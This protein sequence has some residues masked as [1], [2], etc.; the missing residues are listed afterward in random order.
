MFNYISALKSID[1]KFDNEGQGGTRSYIDPVYGEIDFQYHATKSNITIIWF[2]SEPICLC[3]KGFEHYDCD[4]EWI[5]FQENDSI[6]KTFTKKRYQELKKPT[7][8]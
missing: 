5:S 2:D 7:L 1:C 3:G 8:F 6:D 4:C